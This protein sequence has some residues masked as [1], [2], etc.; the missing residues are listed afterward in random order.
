MTMYRDT[1]T[2]KDYTVYQLMEQYE[3][4]TGGYEHFGQY[5]L[6]SMD[7][8]NGTL[9]ELKTISS[10]EAER[11]RDTVGDLQKAFCAFAEALEIV[12]EQCIADTVSKYWPFSA[13]LADM[14]FVMECFRE[15]VAYHSNTMI[16]NPNA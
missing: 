15:D 3:R 8:S 5:L 1:E 4:D 9:I 14:W 2:G 11:L 10:S 13:C 7:R 6:N 12:D 16:R